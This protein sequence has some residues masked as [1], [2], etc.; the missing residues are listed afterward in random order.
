[1]MLSKCHDSDTMISIQDV[2]WQKLLILIDYG[3]HV[4]DIGSVEPQGVFGGCQ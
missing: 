1:M 2:I 4:D 3:T